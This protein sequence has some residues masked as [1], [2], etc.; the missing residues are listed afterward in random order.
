MSS[1]P[2]G[3]R[4]LFPQINEEGRSQLILP[5]NRKR[6]AMPGR[7]DGKR[8]GSEERNWGSQCF[9]TPNEMRQP[10]DAL[11]LTPQGSETELNLSLIKGAQDVRGVRAFRTTTRMVVLGRI[12]LL[13]IRD[14]G[15]GLSYQKGRRKR[16]QPSISFDVP[17]QGPARFDLLLDNKKASGSALL[18]EKA[19]S[20]TNSVQVT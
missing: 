5:K 16:T 19:Q 6:S 10:R 3:R 13:N 1:F 11:L 4:F 17:G 20:A 14:R 18:K 15:P 12:P 8:N 9:S 2:T 7:G